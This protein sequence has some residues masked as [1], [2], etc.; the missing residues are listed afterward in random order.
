M[1]ARHPNVRIVGLVGRGREHEPIG[2]THA[3]RR[4]VWRSRTQRWVAG[5]AGGLGE[6]FGIDPLIVRLVFAALTIFHG[7]GIALYLIAWLHGPRLAGMITVSA[8][9]IQTRPGRRSASSFGSISRRRIGNWASMHPYLQVGQ[10]F[11][12]G[13]TAVAGVVPMADIECAGDARTVC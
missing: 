6:Y 8:R 2:Q 11:E 1:L 7:L 12:A 3:P 9:L 13:L 4:P 10:R 5:V